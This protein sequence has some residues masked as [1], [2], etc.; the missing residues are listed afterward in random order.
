MIKRPAMKYDEIY[1]YF[2]YRR[3]TLLLNIDNY[4]AQV[5]VPFGTTGYAYS[6]TATPGSQTR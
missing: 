2:F 3:P 6:A 4:T 5:A 1:F